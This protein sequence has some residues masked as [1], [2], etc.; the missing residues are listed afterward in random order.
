MLIFGL[1]F[2]LYFLKLSGGIGFCSITRFGKIDVISSGIPFYVSS[3]VSLSTFA[4]FAFLYGRKGIVSV[5]Q[6]KNISKT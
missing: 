4:C 3:G 5:F 6:L 1:C 2:V